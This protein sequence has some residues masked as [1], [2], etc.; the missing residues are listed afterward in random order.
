MKTDMSQQVSLQEKIGYSLGDAGANLAFQ[1]MM[2]FQLKFYTDVFGLDGAVA[3]SV[4]LIAC[5]VAA[6]VDPTAGILT[7]HTQTRWGKFRP[8]LLWTAV[9]FCVFYILAFYNPGIQEKAQVATYATVSYVLLLVAYSFN[10]IPYTS[11]GGV[12]TSDI[13]E[14]TSITTIRFVAVTIAQF[15]VQGLTLPLVH[16]FGQGNL[17]RGW[18][19][20]IALFAVIA[21]ICFIIAFSVSR[22][23]IQPPPTQDVNVMEDIKGTISNLP[24]TAMFLLTFSLFITLAVWGSA[25]SFYFQYNVDQKSLYDFLHIF[26]LCDS[27]NEAYSV[28]FSVFNMMGAIVQFLGVIFLSR[29]LANRYGK[30]KVF[31]I[32]LSLCTFFTALFYIPSPTDVSLL[33]ALNFMKSLSYAPTIPLLWAMIGDV[34][35]HIEYENY[36]RATGFC[37]SGIVMALKVGLG[38]G[39]ALAGIIISA[40]GYQSGN[41]AIQ[42]ESAMEGIRLVSSIIPAILF[43]IGVLALYFYPITKEFN[44][45]M[46][47]EL[48]ARRKSSTSLEIE[49]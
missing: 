42:N 24:W 7:D 26:G 36:R 38:L 11:L 12:I 8:W 9:P 43:S 18:L 27:V 32:C 2:I 4:L 48:T 19:C 39:G 16:R 33:F 30:K 13:K 34:A 45:K 14:R 40:F 21:F 5:V 29:Y 15:V 37:F 22:E 47:Q 6:I 44:E 1:M 10:N 31:M 23:R 25:M 46:Q 41:V 3:G 28:G 20:T 49:L 35:D 17:Q